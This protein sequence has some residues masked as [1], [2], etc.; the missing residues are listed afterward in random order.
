LSDKTKTQNCLEK[1]FS[2]PGKKILLTLS[3]LSLFILLLSSQA[4]AQNAQPSVGEP[5][6]SPVI[7]ARG[8]NAYP[9]FEFIN[10]KGEPD[11]Y[12]VDIIK[13][14]AEVQGLNVEIQ[15]GPW[16]EVRSELEDGKID[17]LI[18]M[19]YSPARARK[20]DFCDPHFIHHHTIFI[21]KNTTNIQSIA[22]LKDKY[23]IVQKGDIMEDWVKE[24]KITPFVIQQT[25]QPDALRLLASGKYDAV[26]SNKLQG[27]YYINK[28]KLTNLEP[29]GDPIYQT[30]YGF[31]VAKGNIKLRTKLNE[32]LAIIK[33]TGK[34]KEIYQKWFGLLVTPETA[35]RDFIRYVL[36][37]FLILL[38]ILLAISIWNRILRTKVS[39]RT[40]AL[41]EELS[42]RKKAEIALQES[43]ERYRTLFESANDAFIIL[44]SDT[45]AIIA[46]NRKAEKLLG[47][48]TASLKDKPI[49]DFFPEGSREK[50]DLMFRELAEG[51]AVIETSE[52]MDIVNTTGEY[53]DVEANANILELKG[54]PVIC[55]ILRDI[56]ERKTLQAQLFQS[57]KMEIVGTLAGGIAHDFNNILTTILGCSELIK[58]Q[59]HSSESINKYAEDI[60]LSG[61]KGAELIRQLLLFSRKATPHFQ[62]SDFH[63]ILNET[64]QLLKRNLSGSTEY[65]ITITYLLEAESCLISGDPIQLE[66]VIMNLALNARD[67]MPEGGELIFKT[68]NQTV[69]PAEAREHQV[70]EGEYLVFTVTDTGTGMN[71]E[72][73][74]KLF[75]PFFTTKPVGKGT[76]L[77]MAVV[78][79][80]VTSHKGFIKIESFIGKG[81]SIS[82]YFPMPEI[83]ATPS[84]NGSTVEPASHL[85]ELILLVDSNPGHLRAGKEILEHYGYAVLAASHDDDILAMAENY[86]HKLALVVLELFT[87]YAAV[88]NLKNELL[89]RYPNLHILYSADSN[90]IPTLEKLNP[91]ELI[92]AKPFSLDEFPAQAR[93]A[94]N[95]NH[96][97]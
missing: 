15:L 6:T 26:L 95:N 63:Y 16:N 22:D 82:I 96:S 21:R 74:K 19:S 14:V 66:Q 87:P 57:Q 32:G 18:G 68:Q 92:I 1:R 88:R 53:V 94:M 89:T 51:K 2:L 79:G 44:N 37:T 58:Q 25:N 3:A 5:T 93:K 85:N 52:E 80:V 34:A 24:N 41:Q 27:L 7:H 62:L 42:E 54:T 39:E 78:Y 46:L 35:V 81:T 12:N 72:T 23:V 4:L 91:G 77:G 38:C 13:A 76:G 20:V 70:R 9:P 28:Y 65:P 73:K 69:T 31:A 59:P 71:E 86:K 56:R 33:S 47:G 90:L 10:A 97:K 8:D 83:N 11:G 84:E 75:T 49:T 45:R 55:V 43:E 50:Y 60:Y 29:V 61:K 30:E 48:D 36:I 64:I 67:A 17:M 40:Q